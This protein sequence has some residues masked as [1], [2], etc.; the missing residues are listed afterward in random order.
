MLTVQSGFASAIG[1]FRHVNQDS[2]LVSD[3]MFAVADGMGGHAAGEVASSLAVARLRRLGERRT[4]TPDDVRAEL[5]VANGDIL[6]S[7]DEHPERQ[8]MGTTIAGAGLVCI[9]GT[10]H[11]VVFNV[12]DSRVY[13]FM[14]DTLVQV[15]VDHT[16]VAELV[17]AG[18]LAAADAGAHPR[19][20]IV[21][22]ALGSDPAPEPDVW[23]FPPAAGERFLIC[24]DGLSLELADAEVT[25]VLRSEAVP[26]RAADELVR[27]AIAYGG[28]DDVTVIV[29]DHVASP[30]ATIDDTAPRVRRTERAG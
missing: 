3:G 19:R 16:E 18:T 13:R 9:A 29:L 30:G 15:T 11:W 2:V 25:E 23:V 6:A 10:D 5:G 4:F 12:G 8:G 14:E 27:R 17:A 20:H 26:Q 24:S 21:T 28:R 7:A 1:Q 22:R